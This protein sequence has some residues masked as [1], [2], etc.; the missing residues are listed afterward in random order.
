MDEEYVL[1]SKSFIKNLE[2]ENTKLKEKLNSSKKNIIKPKDDLSLKGRFSEIILAIQEESKKERELILKK[3][4]T[5][6]ELNQKSLSIALSKSE[7]LELRL[8][9]MLEAMKSLLDSLNSVVSELNSGDKLEIDEISK[10]LEII[11]V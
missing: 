5:I 2:S 4:E 8:E 10:Q 11:F 7:D 1:V 9:K 3:L 6:K